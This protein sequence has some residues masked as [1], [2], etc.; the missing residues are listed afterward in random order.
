MQNKFTDDYSVITFATNKLTYALFALNCAQ[1]V[2][3]HN[4][5][6][7]FIVSNLDFLIPARFQ[8][9]IFIIPAKAEHIPLG[10]EIKMHIDQYLQTTHTLFID[11]DCICFGD[12]HEV[13]DAAKGQDVTVAG[14]IVPSENWCGTE[15]AE[16]IK[17][18]FGLDKLIRFNGGIFYFKRSALTTIIYDKAREIAKDYD[19]YGFHRNNN[20]VN[21]EGLL[22]IAMMLNHQQSIPDNGRVMTDMHTDLRP[23]TINVLTGARVM[24]NPAYPSPHHRAWYPAQYSPL[25]LHFGSGNLNAY[26]YRSQ[27]LLIKLWI[28]GVPVALATIFVSI[29]IHFPYRTYHWLIGLLKK[30]K[31]SF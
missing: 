9:N 28:M 31:T 10:I 12:L 25:V 5:I 4:D 18:H 2:V 14:N 30:L 11:S 19:A 3:I 13:F 27:S 1:S 6:K 22:S 16:T 21:E 8:K 20:S 15:Q 24:R 7:V 17:T 29:F 26:P 23:R